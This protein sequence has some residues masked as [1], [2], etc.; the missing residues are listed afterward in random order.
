MA[1][2]PDRDAD[3]RERLIEVFGQV[4]Q[5]FQRSADTLDQRVADRLGLNRTDLRC[6][7]LIFAPSPLSPGELATAA[8][9][10]T[11]GVTT[12]ID[13]LE[14]S[15]YATRVRDTKDRR[16]VIVQPTEKS[17][18]MLGEVF[19]P[20]VEEGAEYLRRFDVQTLERMTEFLRFATRQ[21]QS[22][23]ARL[24]AGE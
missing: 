22:H 12:A 24:A 18:A 9:L 15:G 23:A 3:E 21:Q 4:M 2:E 11:G 1:A 8:G 16:R 6:L 20:I 13:R 14:R 5:E 17:S 7:E 19:A 10:T